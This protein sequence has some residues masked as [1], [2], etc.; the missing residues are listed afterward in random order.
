MSLLS[1]AFWS[2]FGLF[3]SQAH[4]FKYSSSDISLGQASHIHPDAFSAIRYQPASLVLIPKYQVGGGVGISLPDLTWGV[5]VGAIDSNQGPLTLGVFYDRSTQKNEDPQNLPGWKL[6]NEDISMT[7]THTTLG[8]ATA[9]SFAQ[10]QFSIGT[11][12]LYLTTT[13]P[14]QN[15]QLYEWNISTGACLAE[16]LLM[17]LSLQNLLPQD[18]DKKETLIEGSMRW[19]PLNPLLLNNIRY[20]GSPFRSYGGFEIDVSSNTSFAL[21]HIGLSA[22]FRV[23]LVS[24]KGGAT[25]KNQDLDQWLYGFGLG[26]DAENSTVEYALQISPSSEQ[27]YQN[28]I[29]GLKLRL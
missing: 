28:H 11:S 9:I 7:E 8:G 13:T 20:N 29:I 21:Q 3:S 6:P 27:V 22:D 18:L 1:L 19:G 4:A 5:G 15:L 10:R 12:F 2:V 14:S 16:Q 17:G 24:I 25:W 23:D 26:I